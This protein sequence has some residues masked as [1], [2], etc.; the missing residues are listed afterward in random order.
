[1]PIGHIGVILAIYITLGRRS[2]IGSD[3]VIFLSTAIVPFVIWSYTHQRFLRAYSQNKILMSFPS[4]KLI[5]I[6]VSTAL[7]ELM[8]S[9]I[10]V[11]FMLFVYSFADIDLFVL[12]RNMVIFGLFLA[13]LLGVSTGFLFGMSS[14]L[15]STLII[16]GYLIMP[17]YWISS[18]AFFIPESLP[19]FVRNLLWYFPLSHIVDF[20]RGFY[21]SNY[22]TDYYSLVYVFIVIFLNISIALCLTRISSRV[23]A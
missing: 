19:L 21:Y 23:P 15:S 6:T 4:I 8:N 18:G 9:L 7:A 14:L 11:L 1:M 20:I 2:P 12:D 17:I 3:A 22:S 13:Y 16:P 10:I 5:D